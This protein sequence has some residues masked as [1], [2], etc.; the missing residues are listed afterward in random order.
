VF[1]RRIGMNWDGSLSEGVGRFD[2]VSTLGI[3]HISVS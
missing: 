1:V 2:I 3:T